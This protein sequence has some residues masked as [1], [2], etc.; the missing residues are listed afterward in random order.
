[1]AVVTAPQVR[2]TLRPYQKEAKAAIFR[3]WNEGTNEVLLVM[4]TGMGKTITFD[5]IIAFIAEHRPTAR[6]LILS[7]RDELV[8]QP[9]EK[10][11][12]YWPELIP[13]CGIVAGNMD[14]SHARVISASV[15]TLAVP[16]RLERILAHG[17]INLCITDEAHHAPAPTYQLVYGK[18]RAANPMFRHLGVTATPIRSDKVGLQQTFQ[19]VSA[20]FDIRY[21]IKNGYLAPVRWLAVKTDVDVRG[22]HKSASGELSATELKNAIEVAGNFYEAIIQAH[23][24]FAEGRRGI[25]FVSG[26]SMAHDGAK[27]LSEAGIPSKAVDGKTPRDERRQAIADLS[28]GKLDYL[29]STTGLFGEGL[30]I[31]EISV[32]HMAAYT[33]S[34]GRYLQCIG[35]GLRPAPWTD[36]RDC[37]ILEYRPKE[38]GRRVALGGNLLL[39]DKE[40]AALKPK[41]EAAEDDGQIVSGDLVSA[42]VLDAEGAAFTEGDPL[43]IVGVELHYMNQT[44]FNMYR[45]GD[46][47]FIPLGSEKDDDTG[48]D[49]PHRVLW[50]SRPAIGEETSSLLLVEHPLTTKD[51]GRWNTKPGTIGLI[52]QGPYEELVGLMTEMAEQM[53]NPALARKDVAWKE[54]DASEKQIDYLIKRAGKHLEEWQLAL[55]YDGRFARRIND[56][57]LRLTQGECSRLI[58]YYKTLAVLQRHGWA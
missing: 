9:L 3:D 48:F 36:K 43:T 38:G 1:M 52:R 13:H 24:Q 50:L 57:A 12:Q 27:A 39:N 54:R 42:F 26:V 2:A 7:H 29:F 20:T 21:G 55:L 6:F 25:V 46:A 31:P 22:I 5:D 4:A 45:E 30:D 33:A 15:Q 10:I 47:M 35:R 58:D 19:K 41:L 14:E 44:P 16:G 56:T 49:G 17:V 23:R 18:L 11:E 32:I 53:A 34:D 28:S 37:L 40:M 8:R 51:N